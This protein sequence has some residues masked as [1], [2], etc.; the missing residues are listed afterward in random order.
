MMNK[1]KWEFPAI[2]SVAMTALNIAVGI[3]AGILIGYYMWVGATNI[4]LKA[5][6]VVTAI[7]VASWVTGFLIIGLA[8]ITERHGSLE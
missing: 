5:L 8:E 3:T 6:V 4:Y 2:V 7:F 1:V